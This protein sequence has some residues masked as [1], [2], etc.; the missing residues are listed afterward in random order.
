MS[1]TVFVACG[2]HGAVS[3]T[4]R[5]LRRICPQIVAKKCSRPQYRRGWLTPQTFGVDHSVL[6]RAGGAGFRIAP[7]PVNSWIMI[8]TGRV[9][10]ARAWLSRHHSRRDK[11]LL[12]CV[13]EEVAVLNRI[14]GPVDGRSM[15]RQTRPEWVRA[16]ANPALGPL[17]G[18]T[19]AAL[20][21]AST[22]PG[23]C[24]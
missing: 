17:P 16:V 12:R 22:R 19:L 13:T 5:F 9:C 24:S 3:L 1:P 11:G 7:G 4:G 23:Q 6:G 15:P 20:T 21:S 8:G 2:D 18:P 10:E 14:D